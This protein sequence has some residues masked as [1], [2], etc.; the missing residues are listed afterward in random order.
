MGREVPD[1][2]GNQADFLGGKRI[3]PRSSHGRKL[4][5]A[6]VSVPSTFASQSPRSKY[7]AF[8]NCKA[9]VSF[10]FP[11]GSK[12]KVDLKLLPWPR[13]PAPPGFPYTQ[14][15]AELKGLHCPALQGRTLETGGA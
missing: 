10:V 14:T 7:F 11:K 9:R 4:G 12:A 15:F 1:T 6:E 8:I 2:G 5:S 3:C 13:L